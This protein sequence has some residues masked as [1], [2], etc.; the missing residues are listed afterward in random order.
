[1]E[2]NNT[3]F[4]NSNIINTP[5]VPRKS[6]IKMKQDWK[7]NGIWKKKQEIKIKRDNGD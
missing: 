5:I 1:M 4:E 6:S 3:N 2:T 7:E